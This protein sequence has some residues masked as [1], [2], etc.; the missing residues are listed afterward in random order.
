[1]THLYSESSCLPVFS[2]EEKE[3]TLFSESMYKFYVQMI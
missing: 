1:M 3:V 2:G